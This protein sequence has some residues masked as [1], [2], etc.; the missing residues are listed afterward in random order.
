MTDI[1]E[2]I[3]KEAESLRK[4]MRTEREA[5]DR[6]IAQVIKDGRG[7]EAYIERRTRHRI[8][9]MERGL[10]QC[11]TRL[12]PFAE[13]KDGIIYLL[14]VTEENQHILFQEMRR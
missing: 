8:E 13:E 5:G 2:P 14:P 6:R 7:G 1:F 11:V 12:P 10:F 9:R 4:M 3:R